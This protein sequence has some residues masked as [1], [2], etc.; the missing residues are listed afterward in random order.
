MKACSENVV[1]MLRGGERMEE[2]QRESTQRWMV[3]FPLFDHPEF[4]VR[5]A[6]K[7]LLCYGLYYPLSIRRTRF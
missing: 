6:A 4:G 2:A 3:S 1:L 5:A 7:L